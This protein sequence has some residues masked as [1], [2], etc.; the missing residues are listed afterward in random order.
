MQSSL[1]VSGAPEGC[2][3]G[4]YGLS[5]AEVDLCHHDETLLDWPIVMVGS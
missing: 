2:L 3:H 1:A 5:W 4:H